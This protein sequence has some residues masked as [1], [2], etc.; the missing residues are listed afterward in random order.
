MAFRASAVAA[1]GVT[2]VLGLSG[3]AA[4]SVSGTASG[5]AQL[6]ATIAAEAKRAGL[7]TGEVAGLQKKV[8]AQLAKTP[9]GERTGV[10][11][12]SWRDGQTVLTLPLPGERQARSVD[13]AVGTL[14]TANCS[15]YYTCLY[16]HATFGGRRLSWQDC[17]FHDLSDFGFND[18]TSS[19]HNNQSTNTKTHVYNWTGGTWSRIWSSVAPSSDTY[20]GAGDNDKADGITVC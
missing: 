18:K 7:S 10:N 16:E 12:I 5:A 13:Q 2:A 1:A 6:D 20:V 4:G 17:A 14:G 19:W 8:D 15:K 3:P 11:E 9:G